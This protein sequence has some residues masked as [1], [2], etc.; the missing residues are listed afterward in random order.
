MRKLDHNKESNL[1][2]HLEEIAILKI[3]GIF[4]ENHM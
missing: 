1:Q 4:L 3:F 2:G